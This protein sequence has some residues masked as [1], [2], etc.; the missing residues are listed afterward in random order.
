MSAASQ[1]RIFGVRLGVDPKILIGALLALA[2]LLY[3]YSSQGDEGP[4]SS[5][6]APARTDTAAPASSQSGARARNRRRVSTNDHGTLRIRPIDATHGDVDPTLRLALITRL[7]SL[8]APTA[9]RSL[10]E[11]GAAAQGG[12]MA[13]GMPG[14]VPKGPKIP[15]LPP[16]TRPMPSGMD[17]GVHIPLKF[18]GFV[19]PETKDENNRGLFLDG[20]N[21][22]V[23]SEGDVLQGHYLVVELTPNSAR[24]EDTQLKQGQTLPVVPET[25]T[26]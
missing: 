9:G 25:K 14:G 10:F 19:R 20:D 3:W 1:T 18:Y 11:I 13:N 15:V 7:Q 17:L 21:I 26:P 8:K 16:P 4:G 23:A 24:M 22:L 5:S 12:L 6:V 2:V